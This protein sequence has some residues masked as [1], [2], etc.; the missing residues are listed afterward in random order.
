MG[1]RIDPRQIDDVRARVSIEAVVGRVVK[2]RKAGRDMKGLCPFHSEKT[3]SFTVSDDRGTYHCYGCGAHG[4]VIDFVM[5]IQRVGF[6]E[7]VETLA[8]D[9]GVTI[10]ARNEQAGPRKQETARGGSVN[11]AIVGRW[12]WQNS[13][14]ARRTIVEA[15]LGSRGLDIGAFGLGD[16]IDRLRFVASAPYYPW[17]EHDAPGSGRLRAPAMVAPIS[18][19][20]GHVRAVHVTY[21]AADGTAK[22][23]LGRDSDGDPLD[24]RKIFGPFGGKA[25]W[26]SGFPVGGAGPRPLIVGEG[27]ETLWAYV[28][29]EAPRV[30]VGA[31]RAVAALSLNNMEGATLRRSCRD[32]SALPLWKIRPD[33]DRPGFVLDRAGEVTILVDADMKPL[34]DQLIQRERGARI[35]RGDIDQATRARIC[36][37]VTVQRWRAAGAAPVKAVRPPMGMDFNDMVR[38]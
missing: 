13:V 18:D 5:A 4:G 7:A 3:P 2:L 14:P 21:L 27:I 34:R 6:V 17:R 12:L 38:R 28:Q 24:G 22:A 30:G 29:H 23:D 26:L 19:H 32:G 8:A 37:D 36:G 25:V 33:L 10:E 20:E 9:G 15:W 31:V 11:S 1:I 35:E 16:G